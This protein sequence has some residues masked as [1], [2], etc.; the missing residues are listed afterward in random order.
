MKNVSWWHARKI[1]SQARKTARSARKALARVAKE[2]QGDEAVARVRQR[3]EEL[4]K[5]LR[6]PDR[7]VPDVERLS[8][9][10][11][12]EMIEARLA[13]KKSVPREYAESI[14]LAVGV[15]LLIRFFLFEP[16]K[17]PTG[18]MI[19]T[20]QIGD[21]I[22]VSKSAYGL[23]LPFVNKYL[24]RWGEVE[25]GD[26]VVFPFP[27]KG[28]P[29]YGKDFI[30]RV[31]GLPG[32]R[33]RLTGNR[34]FINGQPVE[35]RVLEGVHDCGG[36]S[37]SFCKC[38]RQQETLGEHVFITQHCSPHGWHPDWPI[39]TGGSKS[40]S[41]FVVPEGHVFVMGDNRDNSSDG[42]FWTPDLTDEYVPLHQP[43]P[44][45]Q[46]VPIEMLKGKAMIIWWADDKSRLFSIV[47]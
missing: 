42:R 14:G 43:R 28:H 13:K 23:K 41:E 19:P 5:L 26:I 20:L 35:T 6:Q 47:E 27:V 46:T 15:A 39:S 7:S 37:A 2:K 24:A 8:A 44:E 36:N 11:R 10:L 18:S 16:F 3:L 33:V 21:H 45:I 22:F 4:E 34:L 17:I 25:R 29:D 9:R 31:I 38:V 1:V 32:D 30:K 12:A 40:A